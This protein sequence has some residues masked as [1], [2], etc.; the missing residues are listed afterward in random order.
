M[1]TQKQL[2]YQNNL[3]QFEQFS[4]AQILDF[5]E[6]KQNGRLFVRDLE[7]QLACEELRKRPPSKRFTAE[8]FRVALEQ[9]NIRPKT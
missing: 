1:E 3:G 2:G 8:E 4:T 9:S 5:I 6:Q 7:V